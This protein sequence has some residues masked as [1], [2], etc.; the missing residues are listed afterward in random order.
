MASTA[1]R[2][3]CGARAACS[4]RW[5]GTLGPGGGHPVASARP[6]LHPLLCPWNSP[7]GVV[8][9]LDPDRKRVERSPCLPSMEGGTPS[10][11]GHR[12]RVA[13]PLCVA[14]SAVEPV[15][16]T[17]DRSQAC[18][19][20]AWGLP[21]G[22]GAVPPSLPS[23]LSHSRGRSGP[24]VRRSWSVECSNPE[25]ACC[26]HASLSSTAGRSKATAEAG[27]G[28]GGRAL[29]L[30]QVRKD[31]AGAW[32]GD[33]RQSDAGQNSTQPGRRTQGVHG[34]LLH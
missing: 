22:A 2:W 11:T 26:P 3:T 10:V 33:F 21:W 34:H 20:A 17:E 15:K 28:G 23:E 5:P 12:A 18:S 13:R 9:A 32:E 30:Q 6:P 14:S 25:H 7:S 8:A 19:C 24:G 27:K 31:G 1:S 29:L 4:T 16:P